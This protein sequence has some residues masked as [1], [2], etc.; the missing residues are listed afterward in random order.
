MRF[1]KNTLLN[2]WMGFLLAFFIVVLSIWMISTSV[3]RLKKEEALKVQNYVQVQ[4]L[5]ITSPE[6]APIEATEFYISFLNTVNL[7]IIILNEDNTYNLS[8]N[9]NEN[10]IN[11][12]NRLMNKVEEMGKKYPPIKMKYPFGVQKM[13]YKNSAL[14]DQLQLFP[15]I[16]IILMILFGLFTFW[17]YQT[18]KHSE[19]NYLWA[20]MAKETAHQIGTPISSLIGWLELLKMENVD[21]MTI[22]EMKKDVDRLT[23]IADRFSKI[24]SKTELKPLDI[25][26]VTKEA[27][28]YMS[29]RISKNVSFDFVSEVDC[30]E[31]SMSES[32]YGWV[33]ENLI[34]N[35]VDAMHGKGN[36]SVKMFEKEREIFIDVKDNGKG[37]PYSN[38][39]D[40]FKPGFTTKKRG[41]GLGLS[42]AKRII[43]EYHEGKIYVYASSLSEGTQ[44]RIILNKV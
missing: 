26:K 22:I 38:H 40:V 20:G 23:T 13:Y 41:W 4:K 10:I 25:V 32:L 29:V 43:E 28:D 6:N 17:Y 33:L 3:D 11:D 9:V 39:K 27:F 30:V 15:V 2:K 8:V 37:I 34:K 1:Y 18:I 5:L 19:Q 7:P 14:L 16:L 31:V 44:F 36:I 35:A 21:D 12:P 42:L 24:G